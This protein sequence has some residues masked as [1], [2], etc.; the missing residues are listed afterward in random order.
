MLREIVARC[1]RA[2]QL[3]DEQE[4]RFDQLRDLEAPAPAQLAA[5]PAAIEALRARRTAAD[6][7]RCS[8]ALAYAPSAIASV[9]GNLEEADKAIDAAAGEAARGRAAVVG[10]EALRGRGRAPPGAGGDGPRRPSSWRPSSGSRAAWTRRRARLPAELD[11]AAAGRR[12][13]P[14][15]A[16]P[17]WHRCPRCHPSAPGVGRRRRTRPPRCA[18]PRSRSARRGAPPRPGRS[19]RSPPSSVPWPPTRPPTRSSPRWPMPTR[20]SAPPPAGRRRRRSPPPR[21]TST[22]R[23]TTSRPGATASARRPGRASPRPSCGST[24]ARAAR[25]PRTPRAR[26]PRPTGRRAR[27]R[28]LPARRRRVRRLEPRRRAGRRPVPSPGSRGADH[29]R[30]PRRHPRR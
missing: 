28:G 14:R 5:L 15:R 13:G 29:R 23:S 4:Q 26:P 24:E 8:P 3:L 6:Q 22:G 21:A 7:D 25:W 9:D 30:G 17:A 16:S 2:Q 10:S 12:R 19:T 11:A 20:R 18:P 27:R 1:A